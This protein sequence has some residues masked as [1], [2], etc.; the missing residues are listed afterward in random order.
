MQ[1][2]IVNL[3]YSSVDLGGSWFQRQLHTNKISSHFHDTRLQ[4]SN[5]CCNTNLHS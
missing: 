4:A 2:G 1:D 5:M 3:V